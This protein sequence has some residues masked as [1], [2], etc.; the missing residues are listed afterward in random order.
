MW[1]GRSEAGQLPTVTCPTDTAMALMPHLCFV[2][3]KTHWERPLVLLAC[4]L[5]DGIVWI[6]CRVLLSTAS[7]EFAHTVLQASQSELTAHSTVFAKSHLCNLRCHAAAAGG[8]VSVNR[9]KG[10]ESNAQNRTARQVT[11]SEIDATFY[12]NTGSERWSG[13]VCAC[14]SSS[15]TESYQETISN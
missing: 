1:Y 8:S 2:L 3:C 15:L 4:L 11:F 5:I 14:S 9:F 13:M 7:C 10:T 12:S 6:L